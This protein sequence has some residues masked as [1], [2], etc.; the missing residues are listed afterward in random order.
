[1]LRGIG[2]L[3]DALAHAIF[4]GVVTAFLLGGNL[5]VGALV[6]GLATAAAIGLLTA[7]TRVR[8]N[9]SIGV[10]FAAAFALGVVILTNKAVSADELE[11]SSSAIRSA[12]T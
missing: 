4:P 2:F 9:T 12:P 6:A 11:A 1:M 3:G 5:L 7:N 8:D 10:I